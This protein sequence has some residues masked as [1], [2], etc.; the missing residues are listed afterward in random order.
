MNPR[1]LRIVF[2]SYIV[3]TLL[4]GVAWIFVPDLPQRAITQVRSTFSV[5][6]TP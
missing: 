6:R 2:I 4:L 5:S 1:F 3:K